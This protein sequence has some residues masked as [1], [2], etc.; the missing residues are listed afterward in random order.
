MKRN[1]MKFI[2]TK[3]LFN[4]PSG[5]EGNQM[6]IPSRIKSYGVNFFL[7]V[8]IMGFLASCT[9]ST[10][11]FSQ[12]GWRIETDV[13][14]ESLT[15][16]HEDLGI[17]LKDVQ[18]GLKEGQSFSSLSHWTVQSEDDVL[19]I[20]TEEPEITWKF[21]LSEKGITISCPAETAFLKGIAPA[22]EERI[23]VRV[24]SQDNG[25]MYTS[26]GL[27]SARNIHCLFDRKTD[28]MV[29]FPA[30]SYLRRNPSDERLMDTAFPV[31][32]S[33]EIS[34]IPDY[35]LDV[36][37]LKFYKPMPQRF[38]AAPAG[39]CS[40]YCYYMGTTEADMVTET[41]ALAKHLR[42]YGLEYVQLD[43]CFTRGEEANY[44]DWTKETFPK[45]GKWIFQYIKSKGLKPGLW[46]NIYG[47]NY[48]RAECA[49]KY[50]ENYYLR[51]KEGN[52]SGA[53]CTADKTVVRLDYS[54]PEVIAKHLKPMFK[55]FKDDW[56]LEYLKDAGWGTW[57][58]YYDKNKENAFDPTKGSRECYVAAQEAL[59]D[60]VGDNVFINGCAMH[61]VGL[62]FGLFDGS[63][64]GGDDRAVWYPERKR[65]MSMQTYFHS[66]FGTNYLNNITWFCD[67]D[68]VMVRTPL[69]LDESRT[70]VT[71]IALTG[72][73]YMASD[74][75]GRLP[76]RRLDLYQKT[77]PTT[78]VVP[79]DLYP[80]K[81]ESN[82]TD[83][84]V[85]CCPLVKEFPRAI[86]LKVNAESG[87]YDVVAVF[88]WDDEP[89]TKTISFK[90]DLGLDSELEYLVF[91][92]W[93]QEL[94]DFA[95]EKISS[96]IPAHGTCVYFIRPLLDRPQLLATS[97]HVTGTVS[98]K[99]LNWDESNSILSGTSETVAASPYS[100][101]IHVPE[102]RTVAKVEADAEILFHKITDSILEVKFAGLP[103]VEGLQT[104]NWTVRF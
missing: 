63:R 25:I 3:N 74:F 102:G 70:I 1:I 60:T 88:N 15:V 79:I 73:L 30:T 9:P 91:D 29:R 65:G 31:A 19:V 93:G 7:A 5:K 18:L 32:E 69:T 81:I 67:P 103:D 23:P 6:A 14:R 83:G 21:K 28:T 68:T 96:S 59:R 94:K 61:E 85:R 53:C 55:I 2:V 43:A 46:V 45:G 13:K 12:Q 64:T 4:I 86:D 80:Y 38:K 76:Q 100:L 77:F 52:L 33:A 42:D 72:Q 37:G 95:Q 39:W 26:L 54:N 75:M 89:G 58:D 78:P 10:S 44:L 90:E 84:I 98:L 49:E 66:L 82:K 16:T 101:F 36:L 11:V 22:D 27:V 62:C 47:S 51:D 8:L 41:D 56:G 35:Y 48:A 99:E 40:W 87:V 24:E 104:I 34:I 57:M 17:V 20:T 50:P 71:T 92:F 97:R